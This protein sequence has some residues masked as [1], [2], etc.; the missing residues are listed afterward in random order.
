MTTIIRSLRVAL[1]GGIAP[2]A[3]HIDAEQIAAVTAY[4][5][6]PA[7]SRVIDAGDAVVMP[8]LVDTHVHLNEPGRTEWEGF[9]TGT[10]AAAAGGVTTIVEMPLNSIPATIDAG[11]L[12]AKRAA[13]IGKC[14][15]DVGF[16]GGVVPGN[17]RHI[18]PLWDAG[19]FG[20]K[21][22]LVPSGV[23]EFGHVGRADLE[24]AMPILTRCDA[25]LLAHAEVPG[26]IEGALAALPNPGLPEWR[27]YAT[28]LASRP[29]AAE[30]EAIALLLDLARIHGTR[31]HIVHL[32]SAGAVE[33]I[34]RARRQG[35]RVSVETCP[36]YLAF[37]A[38]EV[39]D[40]ATAF[41]CAPPIRNRVNRDRLWD[42]LH[43]GEIDLIATDHSPSPP[44]LKCLDSGDF[45]RAWGGIASL[46]IGLAAVW[47]DARDRGHTLDQI[48]R[49]MC[50]A[51]ARLAGLER[52]KGSI[53]PGGDADLVIFDPDGSF[54][55]DAAALFHRHPLT[56]YH[57]RRLDGIV[58]ETWLRGTRIYRRDEGPTG[59]PRGR[60]LTR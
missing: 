1:S 34:R 37:D 3:I 57:G 32:A 13:A 59:A 51:P 35:V 40:G 6:M 12:A 58:L 36:H 28:Y 38:S 43:A 31:I 15:V 30:D 25:P 33:M 16:W 8:G 50:A 44:A 49:W 21:A 27:W 22:F 9:D 5:V 39:P 47:T 45:L 2:A 52:R 48:A 53:A 20:F 24:R 4:D 41:K 11:A 60:L 42:A 18:E 7:D 19:V 17:D 55:V 23:P 29:T 56:P 14:F 26:P 10:R 46:Q 54:E